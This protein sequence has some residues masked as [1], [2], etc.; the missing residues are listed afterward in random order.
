[1]GIRKRFS[2]IMI[3]VG[4]VTLAAISVATYYL[5]VQAARTE[6][7]RKAEIIFKY[8]LAAMKY[9]TEM[10]EPLISELVEKD[11]FYPELMSGFALTR[12]ISDNVQE[13]LP[14][15]TIK[16]ASLNPILASDLADEHEK[17]LIKEFQN[18]PAEKHIDGI[19]EKDGKRF[20]YMSEPV[21]VKASC[22]RCHGKPE[23][24]PKDQ[25]IIYGKKGGYNWKPGTVNS[26]FIT[27]IPFDE[28]L[29]DAQQTAMVIFLVGALLLLVS[30]LIIS[31]SLSRYIV[32]P[33][34]ELSKRTERISLGENLEEKISY[35][36]DDE[37]GAL[38]RAIN[39]L[40]ISMV[41]MFKM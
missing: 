6:A 25:L 29:D 10:Q 40:R 33:V 7:S 41:K 18:N 19:V 16:N 4:I 39:R 22:I 20:F 38:A 9:F 2:L 34:V 12:M 11:R 37:I 17:A 26:A 27:Y 21:P 1:M 13:T 15:Y 8:N 14:G 35:D 3:F 36:Q 24:A 5:S 31:L 23:D 32:T 28:V 30:M